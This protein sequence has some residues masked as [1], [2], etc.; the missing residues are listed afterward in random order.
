MRNLSSYDNRKILENFCLKSLQKNLLKIL[1]KIF[2]IFFQKDFQKKKF[3]R[4]GC[5]FHNFS[6]LTKSKFDKEEKKKR[7]KSTKKEIF[8]KRVIKFSRY[9]KSLFYSK[10]VGKRMKRRKL[11]I[12]R[13]L[14]KSTSGKINRIPY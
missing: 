2:L 5:L 14:T 13:F 12:A 9:L 6:P 1:K 4:Q 8:S 10:F 7:E 3:F 11:K